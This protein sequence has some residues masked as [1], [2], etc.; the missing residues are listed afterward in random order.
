M[1][2]NG[3]TFQI[4]R[5]RYDANVLNSI[6]SHDEHKMKEEAKINSYL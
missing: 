5:A 4:S 3:A 6:H 1:N 2:S